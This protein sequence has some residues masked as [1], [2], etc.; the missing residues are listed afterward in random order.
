MEDELTKVIE[1]VFMSL[2]HIFKKEYENTLYLI[3]Q[4]SFVVSYF[5]F[6]LAM[7]LPWDNGS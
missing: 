1:S 4:N 7:D 2:T 6:I 5:K 3:P